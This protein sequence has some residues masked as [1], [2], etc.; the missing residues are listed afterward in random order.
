MIPESEMHEFKGKRGLW[1]IPGQGGIKVEVQ[2]YDVRERFGS[3]DLLIGPT[4]GEGTRWVAR[5]AVAFD[6]AAVVQTA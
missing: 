1:Y 4:A 3:L 6:R 2:V 5:S